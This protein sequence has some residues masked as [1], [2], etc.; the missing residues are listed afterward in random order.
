MK[1]QLWLRLKQYHF[2]DLV[3]PQLSDH[4]R[5]IFGGTDPSTQAFASKLARKLG[6]T[7]VFSLRA[8]EEYRKFVYLGMVSEASVTPPKVID[9]VWHEHLLFSRPYREFCRD[10][11]KRDLITTRSSYPA[12]GKRRHSTRNTTPRSSS[13]ATSSI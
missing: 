7:R 5:R 9:Q 10:V 4:V 2:D 11:L 13:T 6:W 12:K 1:K 3:P 8:I